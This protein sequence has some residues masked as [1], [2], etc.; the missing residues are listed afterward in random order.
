MDAR[1]LTAAGSRYY[2]LRGL[3]MVPT[4]FLLLAAGL[5]N[6]PP[7]GNEP[8]SGSAGWFV[9]AVA[10]AAIGYV[11]F[12]RYYVTTFGRVEPS[13]R[14]LARIAI[15]TVGG[16]A[17]ISVGITVDLQRDLPLTLFGAAYGLSLL[18]YYRLLDVLRPHHVVLLGGFVV[19]SL[20]PIWVPPTTRCP[21]R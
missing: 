17:L 7:L 20:A 5:F 3:L 1:A 12:N 13:R 15:Y 11:G 14:T 18:V 10:V 6:M 8:V 9:V 21:W 2:T 19:L 4:G 16:A